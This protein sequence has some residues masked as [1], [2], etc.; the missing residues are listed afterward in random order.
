[1]DNY[2]LLCAT[3][4]FARALKVERIYLKCSILS[5][6]CVGRIDLIQQIG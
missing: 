1:M 2:H 3:C 4:C 5:A 6:F